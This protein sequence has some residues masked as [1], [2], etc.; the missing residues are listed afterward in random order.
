MLLTNSTDNI[1]HSA[2]SLPG[3]NPCKVR[4]SPNLILLPQKS[5]LYFLKNSVNHYIYIYISKDTIKVS[6]NPSVE[7]LRHSISHMPDSYDQP[8]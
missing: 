2:K 5:E 4:R 6:S 7:N 8:I 3:G 1:Y